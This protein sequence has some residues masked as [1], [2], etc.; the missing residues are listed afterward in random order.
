[1]PRQQCAFQKKVSKIK[2]CGILRAD[3]YTRFIPENYGFGVKQYRMYVEEGQI[4]RELLEMSSEHIVLGTVPSFLKEK[5]AYAESTD[6]HNK[7]YSCQ[8]R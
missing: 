8:R 7:M 4:D 5:Y 6:M 1:M 2:G 3:F